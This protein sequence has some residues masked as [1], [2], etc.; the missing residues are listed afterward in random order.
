MEKALALFSKSPWPGR[1]KSRLWQG[2]SPEASAL[3]HRACLWDLAKV[4]WET[5]IKAY[6]YW[7]EVEQGEFFA[8]FP[9]PIPAGFAGLNQLPLKYFSLRKQGGKDLGQRMSNAFRE[10][11]ANYGRIIIIGS[12]LP[13]ITEQDLEHAFNL[14]EDNDLVLGPSVDGGYYLIGLKKNFPQLFTDID[15]GTNRVYRQTI[16]KAEKMNLT[17]ANLPMKQDIDTYEDLLSFH[18]RQRLQS[19]GNLIIYQLADYYIRLKEDKTNE[20]KN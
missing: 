10:L 12:D 2:L 14:L 4:V 16:V 9:S 6:L 11:L 18:R 20:P 5:D 17:I 13:E 7:T 1:T 8:P 3:L 19:D 15:W